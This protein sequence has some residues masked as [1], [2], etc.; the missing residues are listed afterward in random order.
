MSTEL[1]WI[2]ANQIVLAINVIT[3]HIALHRRYSLRFSVGMFV[4]L[5]LVLIVL[6]RFAGLTSVLLR[7][8]VGFAFLP[9]VIWLF[10]ELLFQKVF[11]VFLVLQLTVG[12]S[13]LAGDFVGLFEQH[14]AMPAFR[15]LTV[16]LFM[17]VYCFFLFKFGRG[18]LSKLFEH[19]RQ[20]EWSLYSLGAVFSYA[21]MYFFD[22]KFSGIEHALL[23]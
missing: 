3:L 2:I 9:L 16:V 17:A 11:A 8:V 14:G 15:L 13:W 5:D 21:A 10:R 4:L 18:F 20:A 23:L 7:G 1:E 22:I 19:G 12:I 6:I